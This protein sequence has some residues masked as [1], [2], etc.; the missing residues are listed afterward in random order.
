ME[1]RRLGRSG[2][3]LSEIGLGSWLTYG[4]VTERQT[5]IECV[6]RAHELGINH[7]DSANKYGDQPHAA[8][9]VLGEALSGLPRSSYVLTTKVFFPVGP[10]PNDRGLS[11]KHIIEQVHE[12]LRAFGTDYIDILYCHRFDP[13]TPLEE[14]LMAM[15]DLITQG[16]VLYHGIS[17]WPPVETV[18]AT[19]IIR[20]LNLHPIS[21]NQTVYN[22]LARRIEAQEMPVAASEGIGMVAFS[23]L[24][25]GVLTGKYLG[26]SVPAGSRAAAEEHVSHLIRTRYMSEKQL[27]EVSQLQTVA[28]DSGLSLPQLALAWILRQ[29]IITSALIGA[30]N[31]RQVE[32]NV[33]AAGVRLPEQVLQRIEEIVRE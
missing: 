24:G 11:R 3:K 26:G 30:S 23:S 12:S 5:A 9:A 7:F 13:E 31:P 17:E 29:P 22:L 18:R 32:E 6:R 1:Y 21:V 19:S 28:A 16:K 20:R 10:G 4:T 14:T 27:D 15:D 2:L 33:L 25:Q 8:E